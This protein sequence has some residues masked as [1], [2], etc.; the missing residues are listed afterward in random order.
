MHFN[1]NVISLVCNTS[2]GYR[3]CL[4]AAVHA[5]T[6]GIIVNYTVFQKSDPKIEITITTTNLIR[7]KYPFSSFNYRLS[8]ANVASF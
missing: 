3:G 8:G 1:T 4:V 5:Q 2:R 6:H 7:I